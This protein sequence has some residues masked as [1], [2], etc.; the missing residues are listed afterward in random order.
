MTPYRD[1]KQPAY[2]WYP[3]DWDSD[4]FVKSLTYEQQGIYRKLLD[5]QWLEGSIPK[6]AIQIATVLG[7]RNGDID[8]FKDEVWP[9]IAQKF[10]AQRRNRDRL[11]NKRLEVI[12]QERDEFLKKATRAG[13]K[14]ARVRWRK[15]R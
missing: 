11:V 15:R 14:G 4:E 13:K 9:A 3:K 2:L 6:N 7:F 10:V 12:R 8:R 1:L 5:H